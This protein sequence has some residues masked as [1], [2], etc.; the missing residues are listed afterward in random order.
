VLEFESLDGDKEK[1]SV[2]PVVITNNDGYN[3][4]LNAFMDHDWDGFYTSQRRLSRFP[5]QVKT[6]K[7]YTVT[8]TGT[9]PQNMRY[10]LR[11]DSGAPGITVKIPYPNAGSYNVAVNG[12]IIPMNGWDAVQQI[13]LLIDPLTAKCGTNRYVGV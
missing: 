1:R 9:P 3:N 11:A 12:T 7:A 2:Q 5:A 13:P 8:Y 4:V 10:V 6:G